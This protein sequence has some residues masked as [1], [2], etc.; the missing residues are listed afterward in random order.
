MSI[1]KDQLRKTIQPTLGAISGD[2]RRAASTRLCDALWSDDG[3]LQ[4]CFVHGHFLMGYL[5]MT[6]EID[7]MPAMQQWL[8]EGGR[9]AVPVTDWDHHTMQACEVGSLDDTLFHTGRHGI[10]SPR[11]V[12]LVNPDLLT[13]VLVPGLAFN[14]PGARLGRGGGFYDRFLSQVRPECLKIGVCFD[15]QRVE[16]IPCEPHDVV[17]DIVITSGG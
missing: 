10:R 11:E 8:D 17:M 7:P 4:N 16:T 12:T 9:L 2:E 13:S 3:V 1:T 14:E 5:P 6:D 15:T